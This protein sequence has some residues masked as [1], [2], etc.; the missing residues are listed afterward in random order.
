[1]NISQRAKAF[2]P[3]I[4]ILDIANLGYQ[5]LAVFMKRAVCTMKIT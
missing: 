4:G 5:G 2:E 1:M 3:V